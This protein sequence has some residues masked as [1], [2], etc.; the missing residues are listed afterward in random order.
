MGESTSW[1]TAV[2]QAAAKAK[3]KRGRVA[4]D[5]QGDDVEPAQ[6]APRNKKA[7]RK[8]SAPEVET[9]ASRDDAASS[10]R[11]G[12]QAV[13]SSR[14]RGEASSESSHRPG[15][16]ASAESSRGAA[17]RPDRQPAAGAVRVGGRH[18]PRS[19][20]PP[21]I[22]RPVA[23]D[24]AR[25]GD[26]EE[27]GGRVFRAEER[28]APRAVPA[29]DLIR[30]E[31]APSR[32]RHRDGMA[33]PQ[34]RRN[35]SG[36]VGAHL[37][38]QQ[39]VRNTPTFAAARPFSG[40]TA[41]YGD[42]RGAWPPGGQ[43]MTM[44]PVH[45]AAGHS[46]PPAHRRRMQSLDDTRAQPYVNGADY[47]YA[48]PSAPGPSG[49]NAP[50]AQVQGGYNGFGF[51]STDSADTPP[52]W[53]ESLPAMA[54]VHTAFSSAELNQAQ[55]K[56]GELIKVHKWGPEWCEVEVGSGFVGW[57][58]FCTFGPPGSNNIGRVARPPTSHDTP[59]NNAF[60]YV[61]PGGGGNL[62]RLARPP[63]VYDAGDNNAYNNAYMAP[64]TGTNVARPVRPLASYDAPA[65][66]GYMAPAAGTSYG[67]AGHGGEGP[68]PKKRRLEEARAEW[69]EQGEG[70]SA[71]PAGYS[72]GAEYV[73]GYAG[74]EYG[75]SM[76][77]Y[78]MDGYAMD[79]PARPQSAY[80]FHSSSDNSY[81]GAAYGFPGN[82]SM[83]Y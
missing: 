7:K 77:G 63:T 75:R 45:P 76:D 48:A 23:R 31:V 3:R 40:E 2:A 17:G 43:A 83:T 78:S 32:H 25:G 49:T 64:G 79:D 24:V 81:G 37:H 36:E 66:N 53:L 57:L 14:G 58:P 18:D 73:G 27:V 72:G 46:G 10:L 9:T 44:G 74:S 56:P 54:Q 15:G 80:S 71:A 69:E 6:N 47:A 30:R 8:A 55:V 29:G 41:M 34:V 82:P 67:M 22:A 19:A 26:R 61:A 11:L 38:A 70:Q 12:G 33:P 59:G 50:V 4:A 1:K 21:P 16:Q 65:H 42:A 51:S 68:A 52:S 35:V 60:A 5:T 62:A 39:Q 28:A 13:E 20:V